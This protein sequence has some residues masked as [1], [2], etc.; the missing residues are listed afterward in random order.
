[1]A[2]MNAVASS[3]VLVP[4]KVIVSVGE[5]ATNVAVVN[6]VQS[7]EGGSVGPKTVCPFTL[8]RTG[9]LPVELSLTGRWAAEKRT[10]YVVPTVRPVTAWRIE[11][12]CWRKAAWTPSGGLVMRKAVPMAVMPDDPWNVQGEPA[13]LYRYPIPTAMPGHSNPAS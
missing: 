10:V 7:V 6:A 11:P 8:T 5:V 12:P 13:G 4:A 1:M 9:L 3:C 2:S